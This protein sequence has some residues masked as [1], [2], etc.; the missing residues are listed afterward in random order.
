METEQE[1]STGRSTAQRLWCRQ[2][3]RLG[4]AP[5]M[6]V[7]KQKKR[8]KIQD[9]PLRH[10]FLFLSLRHHRLIRTL[11][12]W[13]LEMIVRSPQHT[14]E[15]TLTGALVHFFLIIALLATSL[16]IEVPYGPMASVNGDLRTGGHHNSQSVCKGPV[17]TRF[18]GKDKYGLLLLFPLNHCS[19][20]CPAETRAIILTSASSFRPVPTLSLPTLEA[21]NGRTGTKRGFEEKSRYL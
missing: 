6:P 8:Q 17:P 19:K 14:T 12:F 11:V 16:A 3:R 18:K 1:F 9:N 20:S 13:S 2:R 4:V 5:S 21:H 15:M 10:F 7:P